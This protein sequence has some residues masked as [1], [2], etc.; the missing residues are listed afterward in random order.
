M[1][2]RRGDFFQ[3]RTVNFQIAALD[4]QLRAFIHITGRLA[5]RAIQ[6]FGY[7]IQRHHAH[8]QQVLLQFTIQSGLVQQRGIGFAQTRDQNM[9]HSR[10]IVDALGE[11]TGDF[12]ETG[13]TIEFQGVEMFAL[14]LRDER[15]L[16]LRFG[17]D[18]DFADVSAQTNQGFRQLTHVP[19]E[20]EDFAFNPRPRNRHFTGLVHHAINPVRAHP[21]GQ[22]LRIT[23]DGLRGGSV[24]RHRLERVSR[25]RGQ[26]LQR[27][28]VGRTRFRCLTV[29]QVFH[30]G[31]E[32]VKLGF[33]RL[34]IGGAHFH[35]AFA[36]SDEARFHDVGELAQTHRADHAGAAFEGM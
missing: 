21:Q 8:P 30:R 12:L 16:H 2:K 32:T 1:L 23:Q 5:H 10:N 14:S 22:R 29:F 24:L 11:E 19:F 26:Q 34:K 28:C 3:H 17:L 25:R 35:L 27:G 36:D 33:Q 31:G 7:R 13:K 18:F 20:I 15:R 4:I 6:A 9:M